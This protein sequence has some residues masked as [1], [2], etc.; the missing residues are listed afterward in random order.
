[1]NSLVPIVMFGSIPVFFAL[2]AFL[3]KR[4]AAVIS[5]IGAWLFL[6]VFTYE[7]E[8][9][10]DLSKLFITCFGVL[11]AVILFDFKKIRTFRPHWID[12]PMLVWCFVPVA[13]SV[14][15]GLGIYDGLSE[16]FQQTIQW[17][18][19]YFIGRLYFSD[20]EGA[21]ELALGFI[22]GGLI[23][24]PLLAFEIRLSPQL[25]NIVYGFHQHAFH[26]TY[27]FGGWR[28]MVF[29]QHGLMLAFWMM[30]VA[31]IAV[32][33]WRTKAIKSWKVPLQ[34]GTKCGL[35]HSRIS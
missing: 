13:S 27:R 5:F 4:R 28:P 29:M 3:P 22:W 8:G 23:Y 6:P 12:V 32:W 11:L 33:L 15:N 10:P 1:M 16:A 19:P 14:S 34:M 30:T 20:W 26:Q 31:L 17:G 18:V 35:I 9:Y 2:F 25:H 7:F 24:Y 21:K